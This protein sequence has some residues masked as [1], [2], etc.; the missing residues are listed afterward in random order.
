VLSANGFGNGGFGLL[1]RSN[2]VSAV[3]EIQLRID[4]VGLAVCQIQ[5]FA[6][7]GIENLV[8][9]APRWTAP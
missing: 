9:K 7:I 3:T 4:I 5:R 8:S 1:G 2:S 6:L